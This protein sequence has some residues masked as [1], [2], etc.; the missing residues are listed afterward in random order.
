VGMK[1]LIVPTAFSAKAEGRASTEHRRHY[2]RSRGTASSPDFS[3]IRPFICYSV[4][5]FESESVVE[6][7]LANQL[8]P[9]LSTSES[10]PA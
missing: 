8:A 2:F 6:Q 10:L 1:L 5:A 4:Y 9:A 7:L 3:P